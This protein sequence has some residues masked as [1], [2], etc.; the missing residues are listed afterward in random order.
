MEQRKINQERSR[1]Y[2]G[3]SSFVNAGEPSKAPRQDEDGR[4]PIETIGVDRQ[5]DDTKIAAAVPDESSAASNVLTIQAPRGAGTRPV[6]RSAPLLIDVI[7]DLRLSRSH[8]LGSGMLTFGVSSHNNRE[9]RVHP[10][11]RCVRARRRIRPPT[12]M[13]PSGKSNRC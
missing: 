11:S 13:T 9:R 7:N 3:S 1:K 6:A 4:E 2:G 8:V 5:Y 10:G 12:T